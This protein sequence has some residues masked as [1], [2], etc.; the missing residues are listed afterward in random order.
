MT[1]DSPAIQRLDQLIRAKMAQHR[2][3]GLVCALTDRQTTLWL[4]CYG[5]ADLAAQ[6][7]VE[8]DTLFEIGSIG[9][10]FTC[11]ALLRLHEMGKLDLHAPVSEF[12]PWFRVESEFEPITTHHLMTHTAGLTVGA[13]FAPS[14]RYEAWA[15][16]REPI[17]YAPGTHYHYSNAGYKL[18]GFLVEDL[19]GKPYGE[20]LQEW[21]LDPVGMAGSEPLTT[22]ASRARMAVGYETYYDDRPWH[23]DDPLAPAPWFE[24]GAGDGS[25]IC[26]A[27]DLATYLRMLLNQGQA[28][29]GRVISSESFSKMTEGAI[30]TADG[31]AEYGYGLKVYPM[32]GR[33]MIQH[34]GGT[35]GYLATMLGD[36]D[37]G[38]GVVIMLNG[39]DPTDK[40]FLAEAALRLLQ[41]EAAN[42]PL[43]G[44]EPGTPDMLPELSEYEGIYR[45]ESESL[46]VTAQ[47]DRLYVGMN[48]IRAPLERRS[49]GYFYARHPDLEHYI[50]TFERRDGL[51]VEALNGPLTYLKEGAQAV[52]APHDVPESWSAYP[53][54][55]RAY[56][57]WF[58]N[59]RVFSRKGQLFLAY[60]IYQES[61][62]K[63]LIAAGENSFVIG[64]EPSPDRIHFDVLI[65]GEAQRARVFGGEHY[66]FFTP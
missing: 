41:A 20:V 40:D 10:S 59:F 2:T 33:R 7:P 66:R 12:L 60:Q 8:P 63:P 26:S 62:E 18:L 14:A 43:P 44:L 50:L 37:A 48:G 15:L 46:Y 21:I 34:N 56:N 36:L 25:P 45:S 35:I 64:P 49:A 58:S 53:G 47:N 38:L 42:Q 13:D 52:D 9:K 4:S 65:N 11:L 29:G 55:Y 17:R 16:G 39:P 28:A 1:G 61:F 22:H 6:K 31:D 32:N 5:F 54:H 24:Y 23:A 19:A 51:V 3:P 27:A 57:P 30:T